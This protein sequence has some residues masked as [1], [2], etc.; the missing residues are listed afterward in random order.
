MTYLTVTGTASEL[1]RRRR[2]RQLAAAMALGLIASISSR[3]PG[4]ATDDD[5]TIPSP[6]AVTGAQGDADLRSGR[7]HEAESGKDR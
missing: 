1:R 3:N 4:T 2:R 6:D 5:G 7:H